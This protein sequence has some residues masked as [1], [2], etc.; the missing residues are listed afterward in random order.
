MEEIPYVNIS[1]Q[2]CEEKEELL[3]IIEKVLDEYYESKILENY[4]TSIGSGDFWLGATDSTNTGVIYANLNSDQPENFAETIRSRLSDIDDAVI[5]VTEVAGGPPQGGVELNI[6]G[7]NF[8]QVK[9]VSEDLESKLSEIEGVSNISNNS[10][11]GKDEIV[12]TVDQEKASS[13]GLT[14]MSVA[15][16][17]RSL[18]S[19]IQVSEIEIDGKNYTIMIRS[20]PD[21]ISDLEKL[22]NYMI[23]GPAGETTLNSIAKSSS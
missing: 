1:A 19:G 3:P 15:F 14:T 20:N 23:S 22:G 18:M 21:D 5:K 9:I 11:E 17:M 10:S 16:Q 8:E 12:W 4:L 2:W 6:S 13:I 7:P